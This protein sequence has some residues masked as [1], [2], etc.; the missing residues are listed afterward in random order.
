MKINLNNINLFYKDSFKLLGVKFDIKLLFKELNLQKKL[1]RIFIQQKK[2][3][4]AIDGVNLYDNTD[5]IF[6]NLAI[7]KCN[8]SYKY[9]C[10]LYMYD[11]T[12]YIIKKINVFKK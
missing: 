12:V 7:M 10:N 3:V 5:P 11:I 4:M 1:K 8:I 6:H 9:F 2:I